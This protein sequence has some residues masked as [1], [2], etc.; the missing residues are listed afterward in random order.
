MGRGGRDVPQGTTPE[1]LEETLDAA[2]SLELQQV[3]LSKLLTKGS[4]GGEVVEK[5][6][7]WSCLFDKVRKRETLLSDERDGEL[8]RQVRATAIC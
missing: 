6:D 1:L 3:S 7:L 8:R 5:E 2:N 4:S